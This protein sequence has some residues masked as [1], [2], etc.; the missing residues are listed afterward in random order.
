MPPGGRFV[1]MV[2]PKGNK[3]IGEGLFRNLTVSIRQVDLS[4][5]ALY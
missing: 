5:T 3:E 4:K 1:D 2:A